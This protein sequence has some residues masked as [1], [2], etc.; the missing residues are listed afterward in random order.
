MWHRSRW[1]NK[2]KY[3]GKRHINHLQYTTTIT[4]TTFTLI[5]IN[6]IEPE[7]YVH[8]CFLSYRAFCNTFVVAFVVTFDV[9]QSNWTVNVLEFA[10]NL[11]NGIKRKWVLV[12]ATKVKQDKP[13]RALT[14]THT[15]TRTHTRVYV[16]C[17]SASFVFALVRG[18]VQQKRDIV[19]LC[20]WCNKKRI[21][22]RTKRKREKYAN[23][24][25]K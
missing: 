3:S 7:E 5:S 21:D 10:H 6:A 16:L 4:I 11:N 23:C 19:A 14:N 1:K 20:F 25:K 17:T 15:V 2:N 9:V 24:M 18:N 22:W 13:K 8:F 12:R